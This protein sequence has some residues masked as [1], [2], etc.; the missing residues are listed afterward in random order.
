MPPQCTRRGSKTS[1]VRQESRKLRSRL[2]FEGGLW[3]ADARTRPTIWADAEFAGIARHGDL[4]IGVS[5]AK[6]RDKAFVDS[7]RRR[8]RSP[9]TL[10]GG[11]PGNER[12]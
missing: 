4:A 6:T 3:A 9:T 5:H 1:H 10:L 8:R 12:L 7:E 2:A 11:R